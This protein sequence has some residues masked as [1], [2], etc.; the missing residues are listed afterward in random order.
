MIKFTEGHIVKELIII[1]T[2]KY[3]KSYLDLV[4]K[5]QTGFVWFCSMLKNKT[6]FSG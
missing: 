6:D 5:H 1:K 4:C 2:K 3:L